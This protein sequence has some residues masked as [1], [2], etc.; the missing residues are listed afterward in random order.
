MKKLVFMALMLLWA[1]LAMG[2]FSCTSIKRAHAAPVAY[3]LPFKVYRV[4]ITA[5]G[6]KYLYVLRYRLRGRIPATCIENGD[7]IDVG[8]EV[9]IDTRVINVHYRDF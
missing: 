6:Y 5:S 7:N 2:L 8:D 9:M 3:I 4:E 1:L